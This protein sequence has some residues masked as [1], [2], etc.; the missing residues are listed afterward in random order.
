MEREKEGAK[1]ED[2][3]KS[4]YLNLEK[5]NEVVCQKEVWGRNCRIKRNT[6][7]R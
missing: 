2:T 1:K 7:D 3:T 6:C 4:G 5:G